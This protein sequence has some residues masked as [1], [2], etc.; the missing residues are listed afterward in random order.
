MAN[1][2][3][4]TGSSTE[5]V[6][7]Q[8]LIDRLKAEG[9]QEGKAQADALLTVAKQEAAAIIDAARE[10][11]AAIV[12]EAGRVAEMNEAN[13]KRALSLAARDTSLQLK[14][15]LEREFRGWIRGLVQKQLDT[16]G[17]LSQVIRQMAGQC[18]DAVAE[19]TGDIK[20]LI[21]GSDSEQDGA[22]SELKAFVAGQ[23]AAMF[24][25]GVT[26][27]LEPS[28]QH[29]FRMRLAGKNIEI[30]MTDEAVTSALMR[31]LA[32]KFRQLIGSSTQ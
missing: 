11:A 25:Q 24:Q 4:K 30:D 28:I 19:S 17:F 32:P 5:T 21:A 18:C 12:R 10:E 2:S 20:I 31:F 1:L 9:V 15:Q 27:H 23:A 6:G 22:S 3:T 14:E 7:V 13:G 8:Q 16:P 26:V 29:G